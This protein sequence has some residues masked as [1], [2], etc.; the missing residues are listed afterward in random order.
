MQPAKYGYVNMKNDDST[1][2]QYL[3]S[4]RQRPLS[5]SAS[6]FLRSFTP[7]R[8]P[9]IRPTLATILSSSSPRK[10]TLKIASPRQAAEINLHK[11]LSQ[12]L[13]DPLDVSLGR[14][15]PSL[16]DLDFAD[17]KEIDMAVLYIDIRN[18]TKITALHTPEN[19]AKI[20]KMFFKAMMHAGKYY[21]G[22]PGGFAGD[23]IMFVFPFKSSKRPRAEAI[24]TA[25]YM[26]HIINVYVNP[27]LSNNI[28]IH[29]LSCGIGIDF[30]KVLV[31]KVGQR[32]MG[33]NDRV[34]AGEAANHASR[35]A[36]IKEE[37]IFISPHVYDEPSIKYLKTGQRTWLS[38]L[39]IDLYTYYKYT[40]IPNPL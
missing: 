12:I 38:Q 13:K 32:G 22:K 2:S 37:G 31:V 15:I 4:G 23:R 36:D 3:L 10:A 40:G 35:L 29:K 9:P 33:N 17:G 14:I 26:R 18:S 19:A 5:D 34:W 11:E 8:L 7:A 21:G 20:Y 28:F 16:E 6:N 24:K 39:S 25:I 1:L 27:L 30:G